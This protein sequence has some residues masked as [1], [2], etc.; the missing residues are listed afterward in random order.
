M[1][2]F[3]ATQPRMFFWTALMET[4]ELPATLSSTITDTSVP[5]LH[6]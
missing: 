6:C 2:D 1:A 5:L 3:G 4:A